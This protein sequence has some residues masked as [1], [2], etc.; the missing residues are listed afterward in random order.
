MTAHV[1][2]VL[3]AVRERSFYHE[4]AEIWVFSGEGPDLFRRSGIADMKQGFVLRLDKKSNRG[5]YVAD[6]DRGNGMGSDLH[7][8]TLAQ[9]AKS[10]HRNSL[11]RA[12][13][14]GKI[15]PHLIVEKGLGQS[16]DDATHAPDVD[17]NFT[18]AVEIISQGAKRHHVI[19]MDVS[20]QYISDFLLRCES[21]RRGG[22]AGINKQRVIDEKRGEIIAREL[23]SRTT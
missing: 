9:A 19:Q 12:S 17:G 3:E 14:A 2:D 18:F 23:T 11:S 1:G 15:W 4:R 5:H 13:D 22:G 20:N 7:G 10:Q 6:P 8:V 16:V 21:Q